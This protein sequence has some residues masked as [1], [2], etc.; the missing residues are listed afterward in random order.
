MPSQDIESMFFWGGSE[1]FGGRDTS[2]LGLAEDALG[3]VDN[4]I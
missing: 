3:A 2:T 1:K 4:V